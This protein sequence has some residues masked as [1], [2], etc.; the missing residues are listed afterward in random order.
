MAESNPVDQ[1]NTFCSNAQI[2]AP[3]Y[4]F[5]MISANE[6]ISTVRTFNLQASGS[7]T[8]KKKA[9]HAAVTNFLRKFK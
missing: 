9:R 6:F 2:N 8:S 5:E 3:I 1:L 7:G 4:T